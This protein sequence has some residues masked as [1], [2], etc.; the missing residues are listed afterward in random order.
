MSLSGV[1][2]LVKPYYRGSAQPS[3][4]LACKVSPER[5]VRP[6]HLALTP[7]LQYGY[8]PLI[9]AASQG[10]AS[11]V[12]LLLATPGV[13]PTLAGSQASVES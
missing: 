12:T 6:C 2:S 1:F 11:V 7:P 9:A 8:T 3:L 4:H 10:H 13:D 5:L